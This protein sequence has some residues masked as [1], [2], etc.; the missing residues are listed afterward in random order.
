MP[1]AAIGFLCVA[2]I[3]DARSI[4]RIPKPCVGRAPLAYALVAIAC[5]YVA[6]KG[7]AAL[8]HPRFVV[9]LWI[10]TFTFGWL[11]LR[12]RDA[13]S[14]RSLAYV[15]PLLMLLAMTLGTSM[16]VYRATATTLDDAF[17]G[18]RITFTGAVVRE[19]G[20]NDRIQH[21]A[22]VRYAITCCRADAAPIAVQLVNNLAAQNGAWVQA[23]GLFELK[24]GALELRVEHS[25]MIPPPADPFLY[26]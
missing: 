9:P 5:A 3:C 25:V 14:A 2:G 20:S 8:V 11:A 17:P 16:P 10:C 6:W 24:N 21:T 22:L 1:S 19:P 13:C 12:R 23:D 4:V 7:G 18:E 26:R 15:A